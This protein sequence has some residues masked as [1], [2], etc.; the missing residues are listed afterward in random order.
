RSWPRCR[1]MP[2]P[3]SACGLTSARA[4]GTTDAATTAA[5]TRRS[6]MRNT[7]WCFSRRPTGYGGDPSIPRRRPVARRKTRTSGPR[8]PPVGI[9]VPWARRRPS[10]QRDD[11]AGG[12]RGQGTVDAQVDGAADPLHAGV[13]HGEVGAAGVPAAEGVEV[14]PIRRAFGVRVGREA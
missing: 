11:L 2:S 13:G 5:N 7:P 3:N 10:R 4:A 8:G 14:A 9:A 12:V 6:F 1:T